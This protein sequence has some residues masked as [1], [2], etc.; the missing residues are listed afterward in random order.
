MLNI[1]L[2]ISDKYLPLEYKNRKGALRAP[3]WPCFCLPPYGE[4]KKEWRIS[5]VLLPCIGSAFKR[6]ML[7]PPFNH[8]IEHLIITGVF[9]K[10]TMLS[11]Y[12]DLVYV[13]PL[14][15]YPQTT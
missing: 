7:Y 14:N 2:A 15:R 9:F 5:T 13:L 12:L 1:Y 4:L 8:Y 3:H 10:I 11:F 6:T